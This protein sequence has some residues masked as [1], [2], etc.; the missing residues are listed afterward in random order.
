MR[1]PRVPGFIALAAAL[2]LAAC[3]DTPDA[4]PTNPSLPASTASVSAATQA[5]ASPRERAVLAAMEQ[6]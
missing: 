4:E 6:Y 2:Q 3:R 5:G 1:F